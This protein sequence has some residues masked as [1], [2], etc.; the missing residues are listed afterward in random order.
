MQPAGLVR[1]ARERLADSMVRNSGYLMAATASTSLLG[2]VFW[3]VAAR[4]YP[5]ATIGEAGSGVSAMAFASLLGAVGGSS[6]IIGELPGKRRPDEWSV[7]VT[8]ML[9]FTSVTSVV[10]G[11]GTVLVLAHAG[12]SAFLYRRGVW[13][14]AFVVGVV[15]TTAS[16]LLE[17]IWVAERQAGWFFGAST[18]FA[19]AKLAMVAIPV[20]VVFGATGI[21]SAWSAVLAVTV[22][23]CMLVLTRL[24]HYRPRIASF[25]QQI[26][27]MRHTLTGNYLITVGDQVPMYLIP[28][29]VALVV[30][31]YAAG[32]F[33]AAYKIGGFY[34]VFASGVGSATFAEGS[35]HPDRALSMTISGMKLIL[36]FTVLGMVATI[37]GGRLVLSAFGTGYAAHAYTLLVLLSIAAIPDA[38]VNIYRSLLRVERRYATASAITWGI[39][40][41]R[42]VLTFLCVQRFGIQG[43]GWAWLA[44]QTGG[45]IYC[46]MDLARHRTPLTVVLDQQG[47]NSSNKPRSPVRR[48]RHE[49][50]SDR[51]LWLRRIRPRAEPR[52]GRASDSGS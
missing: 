17:N 47:T 32:W 2:Y 4:L 28:V 36:P 5:T 39:A 48:H 49:M 18:F 52:V 27:S 34:A 51:R 35:H 30:S 11:L 45:A 25:R 31:P 41:S 20:F 38:V 50:P 14:A 40:G 44:T 43:A 29:V 37:G 1:V 6:A 12:D 8:T 24:Y 3:I 10:A 7:T 26:W 16:Q 21:L 19:A 33:Y 9:V 22:A 13:I 23:G 42:L 46:A 15:A